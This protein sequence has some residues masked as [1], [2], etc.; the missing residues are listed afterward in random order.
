MEAILTQELTQ[1]LS[2]TY[3]RSNAGRLQLAP[4][5]NIERHLKREAVIGASSTIPVG[6]EFNRLK[7]GPSR[8]PSS[9]SS[10]VLALGIER[11]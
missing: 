11:G 10:M 6:V 2:R 3:P 5:F 1:V 9:Y 4:E 8:K 7:L